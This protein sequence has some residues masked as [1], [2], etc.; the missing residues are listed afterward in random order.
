MI[1]TE[2]MNGEQLAQAAEELEISQAELARQLGVARNSIVYRII[3]KFPVGRM[4]TLAVLYLLI[5]AKIRQKYL[6]AFFS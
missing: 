3:G 1:M 5:P 4:M 2:E 6:P